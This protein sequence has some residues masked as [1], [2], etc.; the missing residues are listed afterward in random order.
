MFWSFNQ[1]NNC[2]KHFYVISVFKHQEAT[3]FIRAWSTCFNVFCQ[4]WL[5]CQLQSSPYYVVEPVMLAQDKAW[6]WGGVEVQLWTPYRFPSNRYSTVDT[7]HN[8]ML[9][10]TVQKKTWDE[11]YHPVQALV[12]SRFWSF[13]FCCVWGS[14]LRHSGLDCWL[15]IAD[16]QLIVVMLT[17]PPRS[18]T[19]GF[20]DT[21]RHSCKFHVVADNH[22]SWCW[23]SK[24]ITLLSSYNQKD[25][26]SAARSQTERVFCFD[27][28]GFLGK[29]LDGN[30]YLIM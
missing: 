17:S 15:Q 21:N 6:L 29:Q 11:S 20:A 14:F 19:H 27:S 1:P 23:N 22:S 26:E 16:T 18:G 8:I 12:D 2:L 3:C 24:H 5:M 28:W 4:L 10:H 7:R 13:L 9:A 25:A 30:V